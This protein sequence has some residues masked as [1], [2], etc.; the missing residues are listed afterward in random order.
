MP[1]PA[2]LFLQVHEPAADRAVVSEPSVRVSAS[3]LPWLIT[4]IRH[5]SSAQPDQLSIVQ[6]DASGDFS[7]DVQ[8]LAEGVNV[9]EIITY[10]GASDQTVR[11]FLAVTYKPAPVTDPA[12]IPLF[13]NISR[14]ADGAAVTDPILVVSGATTPNARVVLQDIIPVEP[15][16]LG[17]WQASIVL[18]PGKNQI[19]AQALRGAE[20]VDAAI[21]VT[22]DP[23]S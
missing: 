10:H 2:A 17:Q 4:Q 8:P 15:D 7:A 11:R 18:E 19:N 1:A 3:T 14:P 12:P 13:L 9:I 6:A 21:S 22:Y 20:K 16:E 5:S 23:D